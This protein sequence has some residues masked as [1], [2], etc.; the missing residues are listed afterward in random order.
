MDN[1]FSIY[2]P[3]ISTYYS[4]VTIRRVMEGQFLKDGNPNFVKRID[5][6][7]LYKKPGFTENHDSCFISAF[8]YFNMNWA[9][10][11]NERFHT[12]M[13]CIKQNQP[14]TI[15]IPRLAVVYSE[16]DEYWICL[17]NLKPIA[18][19]YMNMHQI[20]ANARYLEHIVEEQAKLIQEQKRK[21]ETLEEQYIQNIRRIYG[22]LDSIEDQM[23][24]SDSRMQ[25][26]ELNVTK[27]EP[28][29]QRTSDFFMGD[30]HISSW[31]NAVD[32]LSEEEIRDIVERH[33]NGTNVGTLNSPVTVSDNDDDDYDHICPHI[34]M[35]K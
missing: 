34:D 11:A 23:Y 33:L 19:T 22:R 25:L 10:S 32:T 27:P 17:K 15:Y 5:I 13:E 6:V 30:Y 14:Y 9:S 7:P 16:T 1:S 31:E 26:E 2:I 28:E 35:D 20:V 8:V 3:R 4:S 18:P 29:P 24:S 12:M 21:I